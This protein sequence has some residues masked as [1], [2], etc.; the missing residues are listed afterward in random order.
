MEI[1]IRAR[2]SQRLEQSRHEL[3]LDGLAKPDHSG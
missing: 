2:L 3:D 1:S